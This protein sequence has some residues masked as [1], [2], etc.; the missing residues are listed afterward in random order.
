MKAFDTSFFSNFTVFD[1]DF[2]QGLDVLGDEADGHHYQFL[3][4]LFG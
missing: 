3:H 1:V 2:L 4:P